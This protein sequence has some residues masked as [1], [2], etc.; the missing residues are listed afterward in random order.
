VTRPPRPRAILFDWDN[1]LVDSFGTIHAALVE[2]QLA[3]GNETWTLQQAKERVRHSLRDAFPVM[4]GD[5]WEAAREIFYAAFER[6][7]LDHLVA[8][9]GAEETLRAVADHCLLAVVSN[10]TGKYLRKES[11]HLKWDALFHRV[12]GANDCARDKPSPE[13]VLLALQGSGIS[14]G[15]D[16]WFVGDTDIDLQCAH[17]AGCVPVLVRQ[18]PPLPGEFGT[19][20]PAFHVS[21]ILQLKALA[22]NQ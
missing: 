6:L 19:M 11:Q 12:V 21:E 2:T 3:M 10:K 17:G 15:P 1:T 14:P 5:H 7:H 4:F 13:P 18:A 16:V 8:L 9:P 20:P 22:L